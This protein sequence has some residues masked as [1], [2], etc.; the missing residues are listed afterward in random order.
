VIFKRV[1]FENNDSIDEVE[2]SDLNSID[3]N[4]EILDDSLVVVH[5]LGSE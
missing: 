1:K 2:D 5:E 4:W 3:N